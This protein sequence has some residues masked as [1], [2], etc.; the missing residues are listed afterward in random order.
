[1]VSPWVTLPGTL[2]KKTLP[3]LIIYYVWIRAIWEM[4]IENVIKLKTTERKS[5]YSG[6]VIHRNN[7]SLKIP[8]MATTLT[9]R[10]STSSACGATGPS[11]R[12]STDPAVP[13]WPRLIP[14]GHVSN[15]NSV[16]SRAKAAALSSTDSLFL[17]WQ[18]NCRWKSVF[19]FGKRI[20]KKSLIHSLWG[21]SSLD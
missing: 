9:L 8:I 6:A 5:N 14:P 2:P 11:W 1:M 16:T 3:L 20:N 7:L 17:T 10:P 15:V 19:V 13:L 21:K 18:N 12:R 4:R